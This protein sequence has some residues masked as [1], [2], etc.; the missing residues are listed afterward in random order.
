MPQGRKAPQPTDITRPDRGDSHPGPAPQDRR[1][2]RKVLRLPMV[3]RPVR[4][5]GITTGFHTPAG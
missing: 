3:G 4:G 2:Y 5:K 1:L